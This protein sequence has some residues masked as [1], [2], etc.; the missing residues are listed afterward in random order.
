MRK[1][2]WS[3]ADQPFDPAYLQLDTLQ[4]SALYQERGYRPHVVGR[5]VRD[6]LTVTV[7]Y[8]V[9]EGERY[10]VGAVY[11]IRPEQRDQVERVA[12][13]PRAGDPRGRRTTA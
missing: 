3:K 4:I 7:R 9:N 6:S 1:R 11:V 8:D 12:G 5:D 13:P 2:L 10:Q